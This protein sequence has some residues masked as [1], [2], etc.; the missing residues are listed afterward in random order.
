[1]QSLQSR[2]VNVHG[3]TCRDAAAE[4]CA[5]GNGLGPDGR[6]ERRVRERRYIGF[7]DSSLQR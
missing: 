5:A 4:M 7:P 3:N 1:V 6:Y 2:Y